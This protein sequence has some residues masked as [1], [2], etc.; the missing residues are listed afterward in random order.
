MTFKVWNK[1]PKPEEC[2]V[3]ATAEDKL[4]VTGGF[5]FLIMTKNDINNVVCFRYIEKGKT[6]FK[7]AVRQFLYWCKNNRIQYLRIEGNTRRYNFFLNPNFFKN[8]KKNGLSIIK[9]E[10]IKDRNVFYVKVY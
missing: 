10:E 1:L 7:E 6:T 3:V 9:D 4:Y 2:N 8:L 5:M